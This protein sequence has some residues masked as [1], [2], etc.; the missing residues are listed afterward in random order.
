MLGGNRFDG[1]LQR[2]HIIR[3]LER[4]RKAEVDLV[5]A[6][7]HFVMSNFHFESHRHPAHP[8]TAV[9]TTTASSK[10]EKSKYPPTSCGTG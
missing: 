6:Q 5:L 2:Q 8:S 4:I 9:R 3:G 1:V 7:C 10:E